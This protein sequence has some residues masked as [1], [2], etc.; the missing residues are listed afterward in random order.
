MINRIKCFLINKYRKCE[1]CIG[2]KYI[3]YSREGLYPSRRYENYYTDCNSFI[4]I[5]CPSCKGCGIIF[6]DEDNRFMGE[7]K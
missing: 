3:K 2:E 4:Y 1:L 7:F 6:G 5:K